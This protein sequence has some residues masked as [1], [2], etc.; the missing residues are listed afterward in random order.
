MSSSIIVYSKGYCPYCKSAKALLTRKGAAF[1]EIEI[2]D[3]AA[4]LAEMVEKTGRRTV[5]QIFIG[6]RYVGGATDLAALDAEGGLDPLLA[7]YLA[8]NA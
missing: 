7:P 8:Q 3:D 2:T 1:T 5:P 6:D 4:L